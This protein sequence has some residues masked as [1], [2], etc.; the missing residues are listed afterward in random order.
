MAPSG[1]GGAAGRIG[2]V[3]SVGGL[4]SAP[5]LLPYSTAKFG[6][7][8]FSRGLRSELG[9][10][11][12]TVTTV[13]P[14]SDAYRVPRA[15]P[16]RRRPRR[17][18]AW[19]ATAASLPLLSMDAERAARRMV[20]AILAGRSVLTLTPLAKFAPKA[21]ALFPRAAS[22]VLA[23]TARLLPRAPV[24]CDG[25]SAGETLPGHEAA[26]RLSVRAR[27]W[28][29]RLTTLGRLAAAANNE[30]TG[31]NDRVGTASFGSASFGS[32]SFGSG[33]VG[34]GDQPSHLAEGPTQHP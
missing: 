16:V 33:S 21:D 10:H 13:A 29:E 19:F 25:A 8:G 30:G 17:E 6:A 31:P 26:L 5:H 23:V 2:V 9:R 34:S 1:C 7:V 11:R 4:I 28:V 3:T 20:D 32:A 18:Y 27:S 22:A 24:K 12:G 14:G 15:G